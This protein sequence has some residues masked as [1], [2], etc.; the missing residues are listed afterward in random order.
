MMSTSCPSEGTD[1]E[2]VIPIQ[3]LV[4]NGHA[5]SALATQTD[6]QPARG[7]IAGFQITFNGKVSA[8]SHIKTTTTTTSHRR[9]GVAK[10]TNNADGAMVVMV[11]KDASGLNNSII[12]SGQDKAIIFSIVIA[13]MLC[14]LMPSCS[15]RHICNTTNLQVRLKMFTQAY[16]MACEGCI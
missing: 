11:A 2:Q 4:V 3:K 5:F 16:T 10:T 1:D 15:Y 6:S 9:P 7:L 12:G 8:A 14:P 13:G